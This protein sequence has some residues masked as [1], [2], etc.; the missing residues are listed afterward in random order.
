MINLERL[1]WTK[2]VRPSNVTW[3]YMEYGVGQLF[4]LGWKD[5]QDNADYFNADRPVRNDLIL[6][7][8]HG[9]VS[10]LVKVLNRQPEY[11]DFKGNPIIYRI[12]EIVWKIDSIE[13]PSENYKADKV[14][15]FP[16]VLKFMG[17]NTMKLEELPTFKEAWNHRGGISAFQSHIQSQLQLVA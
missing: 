17:G 9:Y 13:S 3:A 6:L 16:E 15:D 4:K 5:K 11:E 2:N 1:L 12:V 14:F 7:R 10:H 8:Q